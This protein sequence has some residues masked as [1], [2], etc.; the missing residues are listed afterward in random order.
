MTRVRTV[1]D[2][3]RFAKVSQRYGRRAFLGGGAALIG[4]PFLETLAPRPARGQSSG[5]PKRFLGYFYPNGIVMEDWRPVGEGTT[6]TL[7]PTMSSTF[8]DFSGDGLEAYPDFQHGPGLDELKNDILILSGLQN[9]QQEPGPGDHSGG[10][11]AFLTNR[12]TPRD[13]AA[14]S[15]GGPSIDF[16]IAEAIGQDARRPYLAMAGEYAR[17]AGGTCDT[18]FSCLVGDHISF[19]NEGVNLPRFDR[20]EDI[21]DQLFQGLDP[22]VG[23]EVF[24]ARWAQDQSILDVI[25]DEAA[26]LEPQLSYQDRPRLQEYLTSVREVERRIGLLQNGGGAACTLPERELG[27]DFQDGR[28]TL[29][30]SHDLMALAFQCDATRVI[31]YM[32]GNSSNG[33]PHNFIGAPGGHHDISHHGGAADSLNKLRRID[34]W[35]MRRFAEL[36]TR[37]KSLPDIDGRTVLD[38]TLVFM[39]TDVSDGDAH[40]HDDMPVLLAGH[41]AG[42]TMGRHLVYQGNWFGELFVSIAQG[43]GVS[44]VTSFGEMGTAPLAGLTT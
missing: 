44:G 2:H 26:A 6:F 8:R 19:D 13:A 38:N 34:Y 28:R 23:A 17:P 14:T 35:W 15:M 12:T 31:S 3:K 22:S 9:T 21:F 41:A 25:A 10:V 18:G 42:F 1:L 29:D 7:G 5:A 36:I 16:T 40:N 27:F 37:L 32:W 43:L 30:I 4:L 11:G 39:G 33:R 24:A 20:P